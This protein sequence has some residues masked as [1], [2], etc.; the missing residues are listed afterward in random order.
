LLRDHRTGGKDDK[1]EK[2]KRQRGKKGGWS[3]ARAGAGESA[4]E[5]PLG[6]D[7]LRLRGK[8]IARGNRVEDLCA[9]RTKQ[10]FIFK[11]RRKRKSARRGG[12]WEALREG[13]RGPRF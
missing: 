10:R 6:K 7:E 2:T 3:V 5:I 8:H 11:W 4:T 9:A 12:R 1:R 13:T